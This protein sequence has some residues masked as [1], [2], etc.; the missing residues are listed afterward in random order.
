MTPAIQQVINA[1]L[2]KNKSDDGV[3]WAEY[4]NPFPVAGF[5][6]AIT[7]VG[8]DSYE[9]CATHYK[10]QIECAV[11]EWESGVRDMIAFKEHEYSAVFQS[12]LASLDEFNT[13]T[14]SVRLLP[15]LLQQVYNNGW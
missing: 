14:A 1:V 2:F 5:A 15:Q 8:F 3:Q 13:M 12:H 7:A 4:Y 10:E 11:N 6:L 9:G